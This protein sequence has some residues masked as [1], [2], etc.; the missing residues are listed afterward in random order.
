MTTSSPNS[1]GA[2]VSLLAAA[3][4]PSAFRSLVLIEPPAFG[5]ARGNPAVEDCLAAFTGPFAR[6]APRL[7]RILPARRRL[8]AA[9]CGAAELQA[10]ARAAL[11]ERSP[12]EVEILLDALAEAPFPKLVV[13]GAHS[14]AFDGVCDVLEERLGAARAVLPGAGHSVPRLGRPLND[15]A[16]AFVARA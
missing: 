8:G 15:F 5:I 16:A 6:D 12:H 10:G 2:V 13:A 4:R 11:A 7:P 14:A 1:Y 3:R 9:A